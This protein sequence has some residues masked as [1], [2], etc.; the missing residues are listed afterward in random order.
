V[1][2]L[3]YRM[4]AAMATRSAPQ[5]P[6]FEA[7]A[8]G[9]HF[10]CPDGTSVTARGYHHDAYGHEIA[11]IEL[12]DPLGNLLR[13]GNIDLADH[14]KRVRFCEPAAALN[15]AKSTGPLGS[16]SSG[17]ITATTLMHP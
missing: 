12:L 1:L 7:I 6:T 2:S 5:P 15:K 9:W 17:S 13:G 8:G 11:A 14:D 16:W 4:G 10:R 3:P